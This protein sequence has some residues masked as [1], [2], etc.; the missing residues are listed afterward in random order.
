MS[1]PE[2]AV[3]QAEET[4]LET[5]RQTEAIRAE[6]EEEVLEAEA[7][8]HPVEEETAGTIPVSHPHMKR[9]KIPDSPP[10]T[11]LVRN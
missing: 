9:Q 1:Y 2:V 11:G 4:D 8:V 10:I 7:I 6:T 3:H 5:H